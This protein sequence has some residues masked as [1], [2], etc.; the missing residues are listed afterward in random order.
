MKTAIPKF[1]E[2]YSAKLPALSLLAKLGWHFI[3][4]DHALTARHGK[5]D[6]V[7]M[8]D[9]IR[10][11][12]QKRVFVFAGKEH[13]LSNNAIDNILHEICSPA[14]NE[15]LTSANEKL[16][17]HMLYGISVTE[18]V[19]GKKVSPTIPLIDWHEVSNNSFIFTEELCVRRSNG[20]DN[21]RPDIVCYINGLPLVIIEAK[22]P[23]GH[24]GKGPTIREGISQSLRNQRPDEIPQ[25]FAYAQLLLSINGVEGRYGTQGTPEK[26]WANWR[27]E[28]IP[29][30]KMHAIKTLNYSLNS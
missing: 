5:L 28:D 22:R 7:V 8:R 10:I 29:E 24:S 27:E 15:G 21:R 12:L 4:P 3:N 30:A 1:Q 20:I 13:S 23:D 17:N 2:E 16:Y 9:E 6:G 19:D 26:F 14:L 11:Q 25:L 18:F